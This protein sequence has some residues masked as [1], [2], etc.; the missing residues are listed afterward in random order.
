MDNARIATS[1]D[2][3]NAP[4]KIDTASLKERQYGSFIRAS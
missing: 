1:I 4:R 2:S 3:V